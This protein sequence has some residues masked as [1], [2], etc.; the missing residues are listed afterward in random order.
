MD[1]AYYDNPARRLFNILDKTKTIQRN[2]DSRN[3]W[4]L[5]LDLPPDTKDSDILLAIGKIISI[6]EEIKDYFINHDPE[7]L[8][9]SQY[10]IDRVLKALV[11]SSDIE[12]PWPQVLAYLDGHTFSY[13]RNTMKLIDSKMIKEQILHLNKIDRD[14]LLEINS[15]IKELYNDIL[16]SVDIDEKVKA[17]ILKYLLKLIEAIDQYAI[18]GSEKILEVL[19]QTVGH[20][21]FNSEYHKYMTENE[22]G[23]KTL[24]KMGE[25]AKKLTYAAGV[26]ELFNKVTIL[27]ENLQRISN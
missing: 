11:Y 17:S 18:T 13:L 19:E 10:W 25:V 3:A 22:T 7:H 26:I 15:S 16:I 9:D 1:I 20:M 21:M 2:T 23:K 14:D 12:K 8:E 5:V 27:I 4:K 24:K 6:V